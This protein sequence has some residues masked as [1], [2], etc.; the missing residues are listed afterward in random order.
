MW[1]TCVDRMSQLDGADSLGCFSLQWKCPGIHIV[2]SR[3]KVEQS[4]ERLRYCKWTSDS[5]EGRRTEDHD[6]RNR[7][8][9]LKWK[10]K[11]QKRSIDP[12]SFMVTRIRELHVA[13]RTVLNLGVNRTH[14]LQIGTTMV[15]SV[16]LW[17]ETAAGTEPYP[18]GDKGGES[19][20][21]R[22]CKD[23]KIRRQQRQRGGRKR[24]VSLLSKTTLQMQK[25]H[26]VRLHLTESIELK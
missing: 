23:L 24:A 6:W 26:P 13:L 4:Y 16:E 18:A 1:Y 22:E 14:D 12:R 5:K 19:P 9:I 10:C 7:E 15:L 20:G 3:E 21:I 8:L 25:R 11:C 2:D 17:G